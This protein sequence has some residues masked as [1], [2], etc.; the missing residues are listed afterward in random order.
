MRPPSPTIGE[1]QHGDGGRALLR[2]GLALAQARRGEARPT[3][4]R[5]H[6]PLPR[7]GSVG[8]RLWQAMSVSSGRG[9]R[10]P[11]VTGQR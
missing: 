2:V 1:A 4:T 5:A 6:S 11:P 3:L 9:G 10:C 8:P 7:R